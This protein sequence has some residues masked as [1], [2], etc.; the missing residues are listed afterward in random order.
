MNPPAHPPSTERLRL[1]K[2]L[3]AARFFKTRALAVE[4]IEKHRVRLNGAHTKPSREVHADDE[5][6]IAQGPVLRTVKVLGLSATRGPAPQAALLYSETEASV[7]QRLAQAEQRRLAPEPALAL[8]Q[9]RPTKR[10][11]R[12]IDALRG[13]PGEHAPHWNERWSASLPPDDTR[14]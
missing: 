5:L 4:A 6:E 12:D 3:W 13:H 9:G 1:D 2:W 10:Q 11:R 8:T 14:S 7:A